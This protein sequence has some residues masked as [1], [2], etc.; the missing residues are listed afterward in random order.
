MCSSYLLLLLL[1]EFNLLLKSKL[2]HWRQTFVSLV[3]LETLKTTPS[4]DACQRRGN[5]T[6]LLIIGV[7]SDGLLR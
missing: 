1:K 5:G 3:H 2:F 6:N 7:I 4:L